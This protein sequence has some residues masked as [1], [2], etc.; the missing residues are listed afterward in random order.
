MDQ[1]SFQSLLRRTVALPV[2][3]MVLL[4]ATL[5]GEILLLSAS[6]RWVD[7]SDRVIAT[8][9][10]LQRQIVEMETGLRGYYLTGDAAF[11]DSYTDAK[12][13]VPEQSDVLQQLTADNPSQQQRLR[14]LHDLDL[15]WIEWADQQV[16]HA[17]L[18][19]P[20][21]PELLTGQQLMQ[22]IRSQQREFVSAE[23]TLRNQRSRRAK[24]LNATVIASAVG[25]SLLVAVLLF[26]LTRRELLAL[27]STYER[28]LLAEA[29]QLQQLK[30]SREWFQIT[31]KSLG[32]AVVSTD[33]AGNVSFINPV[34]QRLTGWDYTA[35]AGRPFGQVVHLCD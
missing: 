26:T 16:L 13:K 9:R 21:S 20:S 6:L 12:S 22:D 14:Q 5:A 31:L 34:A 24:L 30:E 29:E 35:A 7:H 28:H 3:L 15:R 4:A 8:A 23:E 32:E 11:F 19:P 33:P 10:Q 25:L 2:V 18:G 27:S 1:R 17:H